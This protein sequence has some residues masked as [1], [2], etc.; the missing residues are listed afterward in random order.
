M[1]SWGNDFEWNEERAEGRGSMGN[2]IG[3]LCWKC[4]FIKE[5]MSSDENLIGK[6]V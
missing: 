3:K 4:G 2:R 5:N 1:K 6:K